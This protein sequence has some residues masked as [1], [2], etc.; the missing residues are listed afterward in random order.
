MV[1]RLFLVVL[2]SMFF[3]NI[4]SAQ[5]TQVVRGQIVDAASRY[6]IIG[7]SFVMLKDS[8]IGAGTV[9][10]AKG[11]FRL[12][13]VPVGRRSFKV[14]Y[15]GYES[16]VLNNIVITSA[17]ESVLNIKLD[18]SSSQL[19]AVTIKAAKRNGEVQNEMAAVS[20]RTFSVD[21]TERYAGS[22]GDP[23]RMAS[24]FA[25]VLGAD[26]QRNDIVVRGNSPQGVIWQ[27]DGVIIPNPN[28]F[29]IPG[30]NGGPVSIVNN[31]T[32]R[33][34]DFYTGAFPAEFG[35]S[36]AGVF[37]LKLRNGN[38][39]Q[40]EF[41]A[42]LGLLGLEAFAEGPISKAKKSSFL[43]NYRYSTVSIFQTLGIDVG[44]NS[45]PTYQD[46]TFK[47]N[48]PQKNGAEFSV[49]GM[50]GLSHTDIMISEQVEPVLEL[51]GQ[52]DRDQH[53]TSNMGIVALTYSYPM[54]KNTFWKSTLSASTQR[55]ISDHNRIYNRDTLPNGNY[56]LNSVVLQDLMEYRYTENKFTLSS[57]VYKKLKPGMV[58]KY[59][60]MT[61]LYNMHFHDSIRD[62]DTSHYP[63]S[64]L[65]TTR[66]NADPNSILAQPYI[67]LK[68]DIGR[69][70]TFNLGWHAAYYSLGNSFSLVEPRFGFKF[71]TS[72]DGSLN[73]G[74]GI[75]SQIQPN[76]LMFYAPEDENGKTTFY[77]DDLDFTKS[78]H[79]VLGWNKMLSNNLRFKTETYY[80]Y[81]FNIPVDKNPSSFSMVNTG[82]GFSRFFPNELENTGTAYNYGIE[83][84]LEKFFSKNYFFMITSSFYE[85]K[86][87]GSDGN[88][89][90][91]DFNGG[92]ILNMLGTK[93]FQTTQNATFGVGGKITTAGGHRFGD[94]NVAET[95][96]QEEVIW[97]DSTRNIYQADPYFRADVRLT[98]K[99]NRKKVT[100]EIAFDLV[101]ITG[102]KNFLT[103]TYA[104]GLANGQNY[105]ENYQLGFLPVFYY[106]IDF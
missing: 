68:K 41:S 9:T 4:G 99:I 6:P 64:N 45:R 44:T 32:L 29:A 93:E 46:A 13:D 40:S 58:L 19:T 50:G 12:E 27:I 86:Y 30:T 43:F 83:F 25:G 8:T 47:L 14:S 2:V 5:I 38:N 89:Y 81:V 82:A 79:F 63:E 36:I 76:Y 75:H 18:E 101:N 66:W 94:I 92:Y 95:D 28:H 73:F 53:F 87:Q 105:V 65:Y 35:N 34:S 104:P 100:H 97:I 80:Q 57:F 39:E 71:K 78:A 54:N 37:D 17:K 48:F 23:A 77:N 74:T 62:E 20:A 88:Y 70:W 102:Q 72:H 16:K 85:S 42:Q 96:R 91:T 24:N 84:T 56:D 3:T 98:Y 103:Y 52:N 61:D 11:F 1:N 26:D 51:Y 21:E 15:L 33:N 55:V 69:R 22:R 49:W 67:Q 59:G 60:L 106:K 31:K 7:A 10:D 90:N